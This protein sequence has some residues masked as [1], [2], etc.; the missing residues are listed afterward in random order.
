MSVEE[1]WKRWIKAEEVA[2]RVLKELE[3]QG[4]AYWQ[5]APH[6]SSVPPQYRKMLAE[7]L[8]EYVETEPPRLGIAVL[9]VHSPDVLY[10]REL[11]GLVMEDERVARLILKLL[12]ARL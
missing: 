8:E 3:T 11:P 5:G 7:A 2:R 6:V 10:L 4:L 1:R 12:A 9:W